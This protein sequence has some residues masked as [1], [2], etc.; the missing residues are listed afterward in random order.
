MTY[1]HLW[2]ALINRD[3]PAI[4]RYCEELNAGQLYRLLACIITARAWDSI[5]SGIDQNPR[6]QS[7]VRTVMYTVLPL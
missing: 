4:K 3:Q 7:E 2:Q 6:S 5:A 1:C